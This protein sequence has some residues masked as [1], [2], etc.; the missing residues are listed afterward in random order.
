MSES[1][2]FFCF[3]H[4]GQYFLKL[5]FMLDL[6]EAQLKHIYVSLNLDFPEVFLKIILKM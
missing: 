4:T 1:E 6:S 3:Q 2:I 5:L